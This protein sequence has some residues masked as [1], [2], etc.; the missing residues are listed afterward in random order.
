MTNEEH[1]ENALDWLGAPGGAL[2]CGEK[3]NRR[4]L[5]EQM[6]YTS[7][8]AEDIEEIA[9]LIEAGSVALR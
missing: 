5:R 1:R 8:D 7:A 9:G 6:R 4:D 2:E 3:V